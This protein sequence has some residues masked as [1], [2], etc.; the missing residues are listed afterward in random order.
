MD[1]SISNQ[2]SVAI[3]QG[4]TCGRDF[5]PGAREAVGVGLLQEMD[6]LFP[7]LDAQIPD[8]VG[9]RGTDQGA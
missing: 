5:E 4:Q 3:L 1:S 6:Q 9:I 7:N 8:G 2:L